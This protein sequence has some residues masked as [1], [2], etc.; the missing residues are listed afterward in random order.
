MRRSKML[1]LQNSVIP[2][3][4]LLTL[5]ATGCGAAAPPDS[6]PIQT[7][8]AASVF[9]TQTAAVPTPTLTPDPTNTPPPT[10]TPVPSATPTAVPTNTPTSVPTNTPTSVPTATPTVT[11]VPPTLRPQ[12]TATPPPSVKVEYRDYHY[13]CEAYKPWSDGTK[14]YRSFQVAMIITNLSQKTIPAPWKPTRWLFTD[15]TSQLAD[16]RKWVWTAP[17][18]KF[19]V[20]PPI[21]PGATQGWTW[22]AFP[23][24]KGWWVE[25]AEWE[26]DG[27]TYRNEFP[28]PNISL[29]D[30]N[31]INCP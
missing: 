26:Y 16:T 11:P 13:E 21:E 5:L 30:F 15:G 28:K 25:G 19:Y 24:E 23:L 18:G 1:R 22:I 27:Q 29:R 12:P 17:G 10:M 6:R 8:V 20:Q 4:V 2:A 7:Q 14:G 9:A 31:Y 3:L